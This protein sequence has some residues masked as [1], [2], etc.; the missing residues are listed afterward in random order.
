MNECMNDH[1]HD[2]LEE[3]TKAKFRQPK[4]FTRLIQGKSLA[5]QALLAEQIDDLR[6]FERIIRHAISSTDEFPP[7]NP[8][9]IT[10]RDFFPDRS[11]VEYQVMRGNRRN[12]RN[13]RN[14]HGLRTADSKFRMLP[15]CDRECCRSIRLLQNPRAV[16]TWVDGR[17][18][19]GAS[20]L[21]MPA[22]Q[23]R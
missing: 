13:K 18:E 4:Q 15:A 12:K 5:E 16:T 22:A 23:R 8:G 19:P 20:M 14:V 2:H 17:E 6:T 9:F 21:A 1:P 10:R 3:K 11:V 7:E